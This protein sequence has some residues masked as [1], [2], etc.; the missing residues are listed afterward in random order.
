MAVTAAEAE[1]MV[2]AAQRSGAVLA[3]GYFRR[4]YP[5][6]RLFRAAVENELLGRLLAFDVEEGH[7]LDWPS[8][9]LGSMRQESAGGG[10][11]IDTGSHT[12]DQLLSFFS[13]PVELV[14]YHDNS[15][16]GIEAECVLRLR[17]YHRGQP[18]EGRVTLSRTRKLRNTFRVECE[19]GVMELPVG[20]RHH[21]AVIPCDRQLVDAAQDEARVYL[22]QLGWD[23]APPVDSLA[24]FRAEI[25][26]WLGAIRGS[27]TPYLSGESAVPV[28]RLIE[29]CY[30]QSR[31]LEEPWTREGLG[32]APL[33]ARPRLAPGR[34]L[35]TGATGLVGCR[36][37]EI[38][39][40]RD[41]WEV[42]ALVHNPG[43]ASRL[44]RLPIEMVLGDLR[45]PDDLARA[46]AGC[47]AIVHC[48]Y[49]KA[50]G[51]RREI[52]K[53]TV[54]GTRDLALAAQAAG[55]RRFVHLSTIAVHGYRVEGQ[56]DETTPMRPSHDYAR[57]KAE[58]E[59]VVLEVARAGLSAV[60][61]RLGNVYG[62]FSSPYTIRPVNY[63]AE[64]VP[65][66]LGDGETPSNTVYV[67]NVVEAIVKSLTAPAD[68]VSGEV[69][70][71]TDGDDIT[72]A[73]FH[74]Y[75]AD[76]LGLE[77]HSVPVEEFE[78]LRALASERGL[79]KWLRRWFG[80]L[81]EV[82]TS[83]ELLALGQKVLRT[84]PLGVGPRWVLGRFPGFRV[85]LR[86]WL[87]LSRPAVYRPA[88]V[89]APAPPP[90]ELLEMF[91]CPAP[92]RIHKARRQLGYAPAVSRDRA[93]ALTLEWVRHARLV[94][95]GVNA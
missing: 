47:D 95:E 22:T 15:L 91:A 39:R 44:A 36:V 23:E 4:L 19:R 26:D 5:S 87:K 81:A 64:G 63:L 77:M 57:S 3:S 52:F 18:V 24:P 41:N 69:F 30:R 8:V 6:S 58:A 73:D 32:E 90:L 11:L 40:L 27:R 28:V 61:L 68:K 29:E 46:V 71:V 51:Q 31:P 21:V 10:V 62:P 20:E 16:G 33:P 75:Y 25:D 56:I 94:P 66:L 7:L 67:D 60:V 76:G 86:R 78:R 59:H 79:A 80:A 37:A 93:M 84:D 2:E 35:L 53:A 49:G 17:L 55:A 1:A 43:S 34:V 12:L 50:W 70:T 89:V 85:R 82:L 72:W 42:R 45:S 92:V 38:L 65:V 14:S 9:T 13:G 74:R 48:A 88:E 54:G 83:A